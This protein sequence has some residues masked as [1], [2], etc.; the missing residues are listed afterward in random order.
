MDGLSGAEKRNERERETVKRNERK[1]IVDF[2]EQRE[3]NRN[4]DRDG[5]R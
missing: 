3:E 4:R 5:Q 2:G 1:T